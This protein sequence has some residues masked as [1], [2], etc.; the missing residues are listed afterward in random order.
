MIWYVL[1][2]LAAYII[3]VAHG[4]F[5]HLLLRKVN[6]IY[7][8]YRDRIETPA[9]VVKL[10]RRRVTRNQEPIDLTA[11]DQSGAVMRPSPEKA[12][13]QNLRARE[14]RAKYL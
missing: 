5:A 14:E 3:G 6:S 4:A 11:N 8:A 1:I 13:L 9:G 7:A 12:A 2:A 10:S